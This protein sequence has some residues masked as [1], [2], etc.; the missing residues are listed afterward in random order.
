MHVIGLIA[1]VA[2]GVIVVI[3]R[4]GTAAGER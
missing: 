2:G 3:G 4:R 1:A